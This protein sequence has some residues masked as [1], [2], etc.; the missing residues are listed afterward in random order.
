[1]KTKIFVI[2][3]FFAFTTFKLNSQVLKD[4]ISESLI[5]NKIINHTKTRYYFYPN[6][7]AY[8]DIEK[9]V[10]LYKVNEIWIEKKT[11]PANYR[12]YSLYNNYKVEITDFFDEKP[13]ENLKEN[14][15]KFPKDFKGRR[16][17][18]ALED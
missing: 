18:V 10:F 9:S 12:G 6:L 7:D 15:E 14:Q 3:V 16:K 2:L 8:Y 1:M 5:E 17:T 11:I 4:T 13:F